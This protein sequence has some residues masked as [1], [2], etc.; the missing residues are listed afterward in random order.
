MSEIFKLIHHLICRE[1]LKYVAG[2]AGPLSPS[3]F[4]SEDVSKGDAIGADSTAQNVGIG[5]AKLLHT[6]ICD[7]GH[8]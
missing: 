8:S 4:L 1:T 3:L 5:M 6:C 7:V 2:V